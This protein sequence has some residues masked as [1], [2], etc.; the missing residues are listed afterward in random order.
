MITLGCHE[1]S[2]TRQPVTRRHNPEERTPQQRDFKLHAAKLQASTFG[3]PLWKNVCMPPGA[4]FTPKTKCLSHPHGSPFHLL[5]HHSSP[6]SFVLLS[7]QL[8][9]SPFIRERFKL[10]S[11][12]ALFFMIYYL[13]RV[14]KQIKLPQCSA[15]RNISHSNFSLNTSCLQFHRHICVLNTWPIQC[16]VT[17]DLT[18]KNKT[19]WALPLY[20]VKLH[21]T[22]CVYT[23]WCRVAF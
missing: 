3:L 20:H 13:R 1:T 18:S 6:S 23:D 5:F 16:N 22:T 19:Q 2:G 14:S 12:L 4:L 17:F 7:R 21:S 8:P 10:C 15:R 11:L 9:V